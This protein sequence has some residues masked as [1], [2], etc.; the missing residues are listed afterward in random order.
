MSDL[1]VAEVRYEEDATGVLSEFRSPQGSEP[2]T[3]TADL[4][5]TFTQVTGHADGYEDA[6]KIPP[7]NAQRIDAEQVSKL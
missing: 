4:P 5:R 6:E 2:S 1:S 7:R 3:T